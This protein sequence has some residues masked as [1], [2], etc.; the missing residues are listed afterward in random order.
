MRDL[1]VGERRFFLLEN[2]DPLQI[3]FVGWVGWWASVI[4]YE[5]LLNKA[6]YIRR[7]L[8]SSLTR[9]VARRPRVRPEAK[10]D[11]AKLPSPWVFPFL[12]GT[13]LGKLGTAQAH[14][15]TRSDMGLTGQH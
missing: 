12:S 8:T 13:I 14:Y 9:R 6:C 10:L 15:N 2:R 5:K 7:E 4:Q 1:R 11:Q 3:W